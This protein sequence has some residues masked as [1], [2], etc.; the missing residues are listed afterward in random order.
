[1]RNQL[2][3]YRD[4]VPTGKIDLLYQLGKQVKGKR[5]VHVTCS[6]TGGSAEVLQSVIPLLRELGLS[7]RWEIMTGSEPFYQAT[8]W[9]HFGLQGQDVKVPEALVDA[10]LE[11]SQANA[12]RLDLSADVVMTHDP[13]PLALIQHAPTDSRWV[14]RCYLDVSHPHR[15]VWTFLRPYVVKYDAAVFSL[16]QFA[17]PLPV[18]QFLVYPS[19]DPLSEKNRELSSEEVTGVLDKLQVP[20]DKPI[21]LQVSRFNRFKDPLSVVTAYRLVKRYHDCRLVLAGE[22]PDDPE[23][24][25]LVEEVRHAAGNDP[26]IQILPLEPGSHLAINALQR[27]ATIVIQQ[28]TR[29]GFGLT[30]TEAMWKGKPVIGSETGGILLQ[31]VFG[32]TG[33]T[34]NSIEGTAFYA[35]YLLNNPATAEEMGRRGKERARQLFLITSHLS[36][37]LA[38]LTVMSRS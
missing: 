5:L 27:A 9:L 21:L 36:D 26:D 24:R 2:N 4:L 17:Q 35:R 18:P 8:R 19:L 20:R 15:R 38:M 6:R 22:A 30:V 12:D 1:M 10:Y 16:P 31:V 37:Y 29:E 13:H 23:D 34:V 33:Y 11:C 14:W 3:A 28:S 25:A 32:Q 7:V